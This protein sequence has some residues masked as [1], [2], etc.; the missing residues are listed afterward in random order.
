M[1][2]HQKKMSTEKIINQK[3]INHSSSPKA[4]KGSL[5]TIK[6]KMRACSKHFIDKEPT[7]KH[8]TEELCYDP[9]HCLSTLIDSSSS[10]P[11]QKLII[12]SI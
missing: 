7:Y 5:F 8:P 12:H 1:Y 3:L 10:H 2:F 4:G 9:S 11:W 6:S